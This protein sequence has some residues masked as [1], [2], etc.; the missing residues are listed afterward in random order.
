M[1]ARAPRRSA[2]YSTAD[3]PPLGVRRCTPR[4][5]DDSGRA[6]HSQHTSHAVRSTHPTRPSGPRG[7]GARLRRAPR[8]QRGVPGARHQPDHGHLHPRTAAGDGRHPGHSPRGRPPPGAR[9]CP[10]PA[11]R[12]GGARPRGDVQMIHDVAP[13][14]RDAWTVRGGVGSLLVSRRATRPVRVRFT[15]PTQARRDFCPFADA[16]T[17]FHPEE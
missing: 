2:I 4:Y 13:I 16:P 14:S 12:S 10:S 7:P 8:R 11:P 17:F 15:S 6:V 1:S 9:R 5:P 3:V